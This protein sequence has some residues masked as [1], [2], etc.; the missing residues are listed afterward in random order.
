MQR[1]RESLGVRIE[2]IG[3]EVQSPEHLIEKLVQSLNRKLGGQGCNI[4][5]IESAHVWRPS[6]GK[7]VTD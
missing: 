4:E 5:K 6:T 2:V 1:T 3:W 7:I